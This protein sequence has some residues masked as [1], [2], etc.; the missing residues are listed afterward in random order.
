MAFV[1]TS[2]TC[3]VEMRMLYD[4][5][6]IENT[7]H[8]QSEGGFTAETLTAVGNAMIIWWNENLAPCLVTDCVLREV[9]VVDLSSATAPAATV[10]PPAPSSGTRG[11]AGAPGSTA[12]CISLR[13][14]GRGR[15]SRGRNYVSGLDR[16]AIVESRMDPVYV[17]QLVSAYRALLGTGSP[18]ST[19]WGVVSYRNNKV[20]RPAGLFEPITAVVAVDNVID[21]QR[22]RLPGR[23]R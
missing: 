21:S 18:G 14:V 15:S 20:A 13:T 11:T 8:F 1:P 22:R 16:G 17:N 10:T 23:G 2:N 4:Q 9:Y 3:L 6:R 5:Q 12:F 7:F 19:V